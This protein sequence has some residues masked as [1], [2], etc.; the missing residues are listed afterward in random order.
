[1]EN[2][3]LD[4]TG[5]GWGARVD[6]RFRLHTDSVTRTQSQQAILLG[7]GFNI[8]TG[9]ITLTSANQS[10]VFYIENDSNT[11]LVIKEIGVALGTSTGGTGIA[12]IALS[13][14]AT[15]GT[16]I[17][18]ATAVTTNFNRNLGS[19]KAIDGNVFKG[20]EGATLTGGTSAG[21]TSRS[22]FVDPIIFDADIFVLP[23][24]TSIGVLVT[25]QTSNT[26]QSC[27]VF[28]TVFYETS[29]Q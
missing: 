27:V 24:G 13:A 6:S 23:K 25:P 8:S 20:V 14:N 29:T 10:A 16:I 19:T 3:I 21:S 7:E 11:D 2:K 17:S 28:A 9:S 12:T 5:A 1:M 18:N 22:S 15:A 4:G 26:S